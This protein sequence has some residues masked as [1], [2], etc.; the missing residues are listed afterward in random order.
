MVR[1]LVQMNWTFA[2]RALAVTVHSATFPGILGLPQRSV[3]DM[4]RQM[5][6]SPNG[7]IAIKRENRNGAYVAPRLMT[8]EQEAELYNGKRYV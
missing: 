2:E 7:R 3:C 5:K 8:E 4:R 6:L 1:E